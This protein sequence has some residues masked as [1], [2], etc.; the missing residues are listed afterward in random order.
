MAT[1]IKSWGIL[2]NPS[3]EKIEQYKNMPVGSFR[4]MVKNLS[5]SKKGKVLSEH[6]VFVTKRRV[7]M[8]RGSIKVEA[9]DMQEAFDVAKARI[10]RAKQLMRDQ[11]KNITQ[12]AY[13]SGFQSL[14]QFN[15]VF[16]KVQREAPGTF[17]KK[18]DGLLGSPH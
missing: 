1:S 7:D 2:G 15:R 6:E 9:F 12:I 11:N 13:E 16:R 5:R 18:M 17:R 4:N 10:E 8:T 14:S 3:K